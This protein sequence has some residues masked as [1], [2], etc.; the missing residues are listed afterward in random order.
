MVPTPFV[1]K[2]IL[3]PIEL[4]WATGQKL[5]DH[6]CEGLFLDSRF[7]LIDLHFYLY[8]SSTPP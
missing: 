4:F 2:T 8:G 6:K 3:S 1:V 7:Y 5:I